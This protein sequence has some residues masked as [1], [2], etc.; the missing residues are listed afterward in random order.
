M[1]TVLTVVV[2]VICFG[3]SCSTLLACAAYASWRLDQW[4]IEQRER[5]E[6]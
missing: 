3:A 4:K 5:H 1:I 6:S 2:V